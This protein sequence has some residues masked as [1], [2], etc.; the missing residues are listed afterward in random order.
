LYSVNEQDLRDENDDPFEK[1]GIS[2][3]KIITHLRSFM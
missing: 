3:S 1:G 2:I